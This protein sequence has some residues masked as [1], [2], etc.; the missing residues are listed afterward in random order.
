MFA[1]FF[2]GVSRKHSI[3]WQSAGK[4]SRQCVQ[5]H[6]DSRNL[7]WEA[8]LTLERQRQCATTCFCL[9]PASARRL[10]KQR[11]V[12]AKPQSPAANLLRQKTVTRGN[13][14]KG[15]RPIPVFS[16]TTMRKRSNS[17][18]GSFS[19]LTFLRKKQRQEAPPRRG[20]QL[21]KTE[22][23]RQAAQAASPAV[24]RNFS[25]L[26]SPLSTRWTLATVLHRAE[27]F[28]TEAGFIF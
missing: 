12:A 26:Q 8:S 16:S 9:L 13:L 3:L 15:K 18:F 2:S 11:K 1:P 27:A 6:G 5:P 23:K 17:S 28:G 14:L 21:P 22:E 20:W 19:A 4:T 25:P 10:K 24:R 7:F